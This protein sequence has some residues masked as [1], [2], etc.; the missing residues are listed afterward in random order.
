MGRSLCS[1]AEFDS[2]PFQCK[3]ETLRVALCSFTHILLTP[4]LIPKWREFNIWYFLSDSLT[5]ISLWKLRWGGGAVASC[6]FHQKQQLVSNLSLTQ[7]PTLLSVSHTCCLLLVHLLHAYLSL[8]LS[9]LTLYSSL[10]HILTAHTQTSNT[11]IG[12]VS[13]IE[14][15]HCQINY[16]ASRSKRISNKLL[17]EQRHSAQRASSVLSYN[18]HNDSSWGGKNSTSQCSTSFHHL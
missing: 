17:P 1:R 15:R 11:Q 16:L 7:Q 18:I 4:L 14:P 10:H 12:F 6:F 2:T 5:L 3:R 13:T 9:L 8:S